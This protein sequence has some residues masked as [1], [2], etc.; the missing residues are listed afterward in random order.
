[1]RKRV[2]Q[3]WRISP[4][5]KHISSTTKLTINESNLQGE[6]LVLRAVRLYEQERGEPEDSPTLGLYVRRWLS[7]VRWVACVTPL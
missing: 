3:P 7:W 6:R 5:T 1:M 4:T 2:T